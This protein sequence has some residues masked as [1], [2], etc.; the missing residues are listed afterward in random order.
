MT[1][2]G[3]LTTLYNFCPQGGTCPDGRGPTGL[4]QATDGNFYGT[5]YFGG[6]T[7][8]GTIFKITPKGRLT[9]LYNF[10][11]GT[12]GSNPLAG[13]IQATNGTFYGTTTNGG[14]NHAGSVFT[15]TPN[16]PLVTLY[17]FCS[18]SGCADG[19]NP[20]YGLVEGTD[21]NLYGTTP[22]GGIGN[23]YCFNNS[24]GT[25][26]KISLSGT[27]TT[28][29]D[30]CTQGGDCPDG[31]DASFLVQGT[32]GN[33]Y[34]AACCGGDSLRGGTIYRLSVGLRPF[35]ETLPASGKMGATVKILGTNLT[36]ASSVSFNG[37]PALFTVESPSEITTTVPAGATTGTVQVGGTRSGTLSSNVPFQVP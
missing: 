36:G 37:T 31:F 9:T 5:A 13:V 21:G 18:Q 29:Y 1:P 34:G 17:S 16:G 30:L 35:V 33:F 15:I 8:N 14:L 3:K 27:L 6:A 11:G 26:F 2:G 28:L 23:S 12:D 20:F 32:D 19:F 4:I 25:V 24:C 22:Y 10:T 7:N